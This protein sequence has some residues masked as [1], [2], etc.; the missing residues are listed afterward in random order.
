MCDIPPLAL[1]ISF[2]LFVDAGIP[3]DPEEWEIF[4]GITFLRKEHFLVGGFFSL[5]K[6]NFLLQLETV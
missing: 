2:K 5:F 1:L 3:R 6:R 4:T